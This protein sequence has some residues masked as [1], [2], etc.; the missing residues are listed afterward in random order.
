MWRRVLGFSPL[1]NQVILDSH[2]ITEDSTKMCYMEVLEHQ[3]LASWLSQLGVWEIGAFS[4]VLSLPWTNLSPTANSPPVLFKAPTGQALFTSS[5]GYYSHL[6]RSLPDSTLSP[7]RFIRHE[8]AR[9]IRQQDHVSSSPPPELNRL[10]L[11]AWSSEALHPSFP[12]RLSTLPTFSFFLWKCPTCPH[13]LRSCPSH[14]TLQWNLQ[15]FQTSLF[16]THAAVLASLHIE[17]S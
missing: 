17:N 4:T 9:E 5:H 2:P 11:Q 15:A 7:T 12:L 1:G 10:G 16:W 13:S 6:P 3:D 8:L 14:P